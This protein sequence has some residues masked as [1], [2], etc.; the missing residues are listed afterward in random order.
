M[1]KKNEQALLA[2]AKRHGFNS[3]DEF[4]GYQPESQ[5]ENH[6]NQALS[7]FEQ[8]APEAPEKNVKNHVE[9]TDKKV[10]ENQKEKDSGKTNS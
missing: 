2:Y 8:Q 9:K 6:Q 7:D 5:K 4:I 10:I 3:W 1:E